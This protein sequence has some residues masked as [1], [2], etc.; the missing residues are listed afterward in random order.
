MSA[1][2]TRADQQADPCEASSNMASAYLDHTA[3]ER[4]AN[5]LA[6]LAL[7]HVF[8]RSARSLADD[9]VRTGMCTVTDLR[10]QGARLFVD[11]SRLARGD[12]SRIRVPNRLARPGEYTVADWNALLEVVIL[13]PNSASAPVMGPPRNALAAARAAL[14]DD[15]P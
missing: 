1:A 10:W 8:G 14:R 12:L 13:C 6:S 4:R 5:H 11:L 3:L 2:V 7:A 9:A 15:A